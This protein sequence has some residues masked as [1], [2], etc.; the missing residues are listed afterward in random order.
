MK[1]KRLL[2]SIVFCAL[3]SGCYKDDVSI[4][5]SRQHELEKELE[6]IQNQITT[7]NN[8]IDI[9]N[10]II[11][12]MELDDCVTGVEELPDGSGYK[13]TFRKSGDKIIY[14]GNT[15]IVGENG[16]WHIGGTDTGVNAQ[17]LAGADGN[18]PYI[19]SNG[20]WWCGATDTGVKAEGADGSTPHVGSNGNWWCGTTD[21]GVKARG[22]DGYSP[23]IGSNGNWH[24]NGVDLGV[25][26]QGGNGSDGQTP[27]IH[28]NGNWWIGTNDLGV[29]AQGADGTTPHIGANGNWWIGSTDTNVPATG[30]D[31]LNPHIGS[32]G[33]WWIGTTDTGV[34]ARGENGLSPEIGANGNWWIG[35]T[36]TGVKAQGN[37][38]KTPVISVA[39][40]ASNPSDPNYYWTRKIGDGAAEFILVDGNKVKANGTD[41]AS[42]AT[43]VVGIKQD[44]DLEYYWTVTI[45][46]AAETWIL[47]NGNK[48]KATGQKGDKG[49]AGDSFFKSVD[50]SNDDYIIF[51]LNTEPAASF[52]VPRYRT[53]QFAMPVSPIVFDRFNETKVLPFTISANVVSVQATAPDG[54]RTEVDMTAK[55][56]TVT[57]PSAYN[58]FA[59]TT[60]ALS[61]VAFDNKGMATSVTSQME[62]GSTIRLSFRRGNSGTAFT[63][64]YVPY[65]IRVFYFPSDGPFVQGD[66]QSD[67]VPQGT[68]VSGIHNTGRE[69]QTRGWTMVSWGDDP[70]VTWEDHNPSGDGPRDLYDVEATLKPDPTRTGWYMPLASNVP[71]MWWQKTEFPKSAAVNNPTQMN[72]YVA[73]ARVTV[74]LHRVDQITVPGVSDPDPSKFWISFENQGRTCDFFEGEVGKR[75]RGSLPLT[76]PLALDMTY[77]SSSKIATSGAFGSFG[78]LTPVSGDPDNRQIVIRV[79]Y[80]NTEIHALKFTDSSATI[81]MGSTYTFN[82]NQSV[83]MG[84][85]ITVN[86]WNMV[87]ASVTLQ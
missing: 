32:N 45:A 55:T 87:W 17:G 57:S 27:Y 54:W 41:G 72:Q 42:G 24:S 5:Y 73:S 36:D 40:D 9:I 69:N 86:G 66:L 44:T 74:N 21:T 60:G 15:P 79:M 2:F 49:D 63:A 82:I 10:S 50:Y 75:P 68:C 80:E 20:N 51:E 78:T 85:S 48:V 70:N 25:K 26:A 46:P 35:S 4:L 19:H 53:I 43:P 56:V 58:Y 47:V 18:S 33:N 8:H 6:V 37:D 11:N 65:G 1:K 61:L 23:Y 34:K 62:V 81:S 76:V 59:Q 71:N 13:L 31:G 14:H 52:S 16:N 22:E 3:F 38:G 67:L 83:Y 64:A 39:Q 77:N 84:I 7:I 29:K 28:S 12:S 30:A